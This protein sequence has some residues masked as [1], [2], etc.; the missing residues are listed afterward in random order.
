MYD[1]DTYSPHDIAPRDPDSC[2]VSD[3]VRS[4]LAEFLERVSCDTDDQSIPAFVQRELKALSECGDFTRGFLRLRCGDCR[5]DRIVPFRC[6][7]R[8]CPSCAGRRMSD[9]AAWLVD[10]VLQPTIGYRQFVLTFP[11]P[12]AVGLCFR[13]E[14]ASAVIRLCMRVLFEYQRARSGDDPN[15]KPHPG[16]IVWI[17]RFSDG[18]GA[19]LH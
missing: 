9:T 19:W 18:G 4:H 16:G 3:I 5:D 13:E 15:S 11:A 2:V 17:Q 7:S 14:A 10:R 12:L 6:K 1:P 8:L